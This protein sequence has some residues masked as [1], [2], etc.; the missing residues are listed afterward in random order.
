MTAPAQ[1]S[2]DPWARF[3]WL[4]GA[5]WIFFLAFPLNAALEAP[6]IARQTAG[7][8]LLVAFGCAYL[9]GLWWSFRQEDRARSDG[10]SWALLAS[11]VS[12][13]LASALVIGAD[14]VSLLPFIVSVA[15]FTLPR[16]GAITVGALSV[17]V[18]ALVPLLTGDLHERA[19]FVGIVA[20]VALLTLT[21][22]LVN[23]RQAEHDAEAE[24]F[25]LLAERERVSRDVHDVLGHS[26]TVISIKAEL[27]DRLVDRDPARARTELAEIQ[28]LTREAL[29]EIRATVS[30][31]RVARL[32]DELAAALAALTAAG[33]EA[34]VPDDAAALDP[35]HRIVA[36]WVV[37]EAVTNVVRHSGATRC[38]IELQPHRLRVIDDGI[39]PDGSGT[40]D[41]H[42]TGLRG[43]SERVNTSG[44]TLAVTSGPGGR[45]TTVAVTW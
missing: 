26:L 15:A 10:P 34:V 17:A 7:V 29:A 6:G 19:F 30:G 20:A 28:S 38:T 21:V 24:E 5:V 4:M 35:R 12:L 23:E 1:L 3:G 44:G 27:A 2:R 43:L 11:L 41:T 8:V 36:A 40:G 9:L 32:V 18:A 45:G 14:A 16:A 33:I 31:L 37:R 22:R 42:G 25:A 39:G 13:Q